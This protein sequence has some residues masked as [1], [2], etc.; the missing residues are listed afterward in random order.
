MHSCIYA[1]KNVFMDK[2]IIINNHHQ[3]KAQIGILEKK[4]LKP[5]L[6]LENKNYQSNIH[7]FQILLF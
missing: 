4:I 5:I 1:K 2:G 6:V 7:K 3:N